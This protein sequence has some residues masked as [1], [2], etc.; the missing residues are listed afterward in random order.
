MKDVV[1]LVSKQV[2]PEPTPRMRKAKGSC[3]IS[4]AHPLVKVLLQ[5]VEAQLL[6][7]RNDRS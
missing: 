6:L 7:L 1:F 3:I 5:A 2:F 4:T